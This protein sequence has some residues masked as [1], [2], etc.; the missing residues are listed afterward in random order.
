M[1]KAA[2]DEVGSFIAQAVLIKIYKTRKCQV[3]FPRFC[4]HNVSPSTPIHPKASYQ[5]SGFQN[6]WY[7]FMR[8][9]LI[10]GS[11]SYPVNCNRR[12][13]TQRIKP[14][15]KW[16]FVFL[17]DLSNTKENAVSLLQKHFLISA[18]DWP[19]ADLFTSLFL[20]TGRMC[21]RKNIIETTTCCQ[22]ALD[23]KKWYVCSSQNKS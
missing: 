5:P 9:A 8:A 20:K 13:P 16:A 22:N 14:P 12:I 23:M 18:G 15:V 7:W 21:F 10:S 2:A 3:A 6:R 19:A 4:V 17:A 1:Q 11:I